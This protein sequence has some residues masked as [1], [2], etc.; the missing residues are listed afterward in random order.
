MNTLTKLPRNHRLK[1]TRAANVMRYE[2]GAG[3][4][5]ARRR[6][7]WQSDEIEHVLTYA[8]FG[9]SAETIAQATQLSPG[10]VTYRL[11]KTQTSLRAYRRGESA[12][13]Q[14]ILRIGGQQ[15]PVVA[16]LK[17][18][19]EAA[20]HQRLRQLGLIPPPA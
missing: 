13:A 16:K 14:Q 9:F 20:T 7:N 5:G 11:G 2:A 10:Q 4:T 6:I 3:V 12:L 19:I 18:S 8:E 17:H 15:L 1:D